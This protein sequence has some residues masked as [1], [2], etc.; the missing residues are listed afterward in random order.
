MISQPVYEINLTALA[1][2]EI[3]LNCLKLGFVKLFCISHIATTLSLKKKPPQF[4]A[5]SFSS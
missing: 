5:V 2:K 1:D 3:Q 4:K